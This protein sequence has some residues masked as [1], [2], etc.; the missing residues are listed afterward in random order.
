M[1][2]KIVNN[3]DHPTEIYPRNTRNTAVRVRG[4]RG[5]PKSYTVPEPVLPVLETPRVSPYPCGTLLSTHLH[6]SLI[7]SFLTNKSDKKYSKML[8]IRLRVCNI[9]LSI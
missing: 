2:T 7:S 9:L 1:T 8:R 5:V 3:E 4:V 6:L